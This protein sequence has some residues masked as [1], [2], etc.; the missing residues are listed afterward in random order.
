M[1]ARRVVAEELSRERILMEARALFA[2]NGYDK[3][4]M[5]SIAKA[6]GYSHGALY[7]HFRDKAELFYALVVE[8]FN[9]LLNM[10]RE[11]LEKTEI[12]E[13]SQLKTLMLEFVRFGLSNPHH[14][15]IM[16]MV[17]DP[18]LKR[19]SRTKQAQ[20]LEMFSSVVRRVMEGRPDADK[21]LYTLPWSIFMSM[22]GF[23]SYSIHFY[24][25]FEEVRPFAE[26]HINYICEGIG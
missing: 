12:R 5:R 23:I 14:Y 18:D 8:D 17:R 2:M 26:E 11:L 22:H 13:I 7:Y 10:Q 1:C 6:L 25:T 21:G 16:F 15:E 20:C 4:T 3:L 9:G 24:Q 19:Y